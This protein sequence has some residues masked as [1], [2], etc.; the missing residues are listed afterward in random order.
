VSA[1]QE[2]PHVVRE[3]GARLPFRPRRKN[4]RSF[5][6]LRMIAAELGRSAKRDHI[7]AVGGAGSSGLPAFASGT[8]T[9]TATRMASA[10]TAVI[11]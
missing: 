6:S 3:D 4:R 5:A 1:R 8:K 11:R 2:I 7:I 10:M 9:I